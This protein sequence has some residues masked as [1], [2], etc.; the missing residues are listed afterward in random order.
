MTVAKVAKTNTS[1][2]Y[3]W[4]SGAHKPFPIRLKWISEK[5]GKP[6]TWDLMGPM[7]KDEIA[8]RINGIGGPRIAS[9]L[10]GVHENTIGQWALGRWSPSPRHLVALRRLAPTYTV[11]DT[12]PMSREELLRILRVI[13]L[14]NVCVA[15]GCSELV[16]KSWFRGKAS[17]RLKYRAKLRRAYRDRQIPPR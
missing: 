9:K 11:E 10:L 5:L 16:P 12:S 13:G 17:P 3:R 7:S 8:A 15:V 1:V 6:P 2:V 14:E 4:I